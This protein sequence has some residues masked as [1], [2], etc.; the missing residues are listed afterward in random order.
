MHDESKLLDRFPSAPGN[1]GAAPTIE[2]S[3]ICT[4]TNPLA[5]STITTS[6][7]PCER[8]EGR[9]VKLSTFATKQLQLAPIAVIR[10]FCHQGAVRVLAYI[11]AAA[12]TLSSCSP[13]EPENVSTSAPAPTL[14]E[15][16]RALVRCRSEVDRPSC[17][18]AESNRHSPA[19]PKLCNLARARPSC[20][21]AEGQQFCGKAHIGNDG[22]CAIEVY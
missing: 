3:Q 16:T 1:N 4:E 22:R 21:T 11:A 2:V 14:S 13:G 9:G 12:V 7:P 6:A 15:V 5:H 10:T 20:V 18:V 17:L 19:D 8:P